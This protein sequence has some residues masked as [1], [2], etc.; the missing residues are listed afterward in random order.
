[1][2]KKLVLLT[3]IICTLLCG[4]QPKNPSAAMAQVTGSEPQSGYTGEYVSP[5]DDEPP[6]Y[7]IPMTDI[8]GTSAE[9]STAFSSATAR[10]STAPSAARPSTTIPRTSA[11]RPTAP[12]TKPT[13]TAQPSKPAA[14]KKIYGVWISCYDHPSAAGKTAEE[15]RA[16]TDAM[17]KKISDFG[18]NT[19]FVHMVAFSDAFY[20]SDI[21]P[22]SSYIAG[23][24]GASLSFDPFAILLSSAKKY[25]VEVH[26]WIN[27]FRV[28]HKSDPALLSEK[29]P[30]KAI[31]DSGNADG[32][33]CILPNGI[34]YNPASTAVHSRIIAGVK[35]IIGKYDIAGIHI[36]D[37]F[38]PSTDK[39]VDEKQY[40][41]YTAAGGKLSLKEWRIG[42][43]NAFVSSLY[44]AVKAADPTLTVSIS[45]AAQMDKNKNTL[46]ADCGRWL[47]T[48]GYADIIIPQIYFGFRHEKCDFNSMLAQWGALKRSP[49]VRLLCGIAAYKCGKEDKYAGTGSKEWLESSDIMLRQAQSIAANKNYDGFVV[50]SYSDLGRK[51]C[52]DEMKR[53]KDYIKSNG[54]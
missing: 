49:N 45:P 35:E 44:S 25:G 8:I 50:Y 3:I 6:P 39:S 54:D 14:G 33:I 46:Y 30:A 29:N 28:S 26:G 43:V 5:A 9:N 22:Y 34:Y 37:Y 31:L 36:D 11:V 24:E 12:V 20:K 41:A 2:R 1:M 42:C 23:K 7:D 16:S 13:Q 52:S 10:Q 47:S 19:A 15:Y 38:Y 53:L 17:F 27:P 32:D 48:D 40:S 51:S 18:L 21:Y 4:C